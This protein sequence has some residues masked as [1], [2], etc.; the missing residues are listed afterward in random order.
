[1]HAPGVLAPVQVVHTESVSATPATAAPTDR[2]DRPAPAP[3]PSGAELG[4]LCGTVRDGEGHPVTRAQ[5]MMADAG[6]VFLTDRSGRFCLTV[7]VGERTL[8]VVALGFT[9]ERLLIIVSKRTPELTVTL[10]AAAPYPVMP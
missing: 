9:S 8:S 5:V 1:M 6:V 2:M 3:A 4:V 7:P 10:Q